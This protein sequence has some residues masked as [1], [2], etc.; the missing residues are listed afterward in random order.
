MNFLPRSRDELEKVWTEETNLSRR[1]LLS[2]NT[3]P[4]TVEDLTQ[5]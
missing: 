5:V 4:E 3:G 2:L 1:R